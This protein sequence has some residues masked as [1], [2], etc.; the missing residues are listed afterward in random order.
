MVCL[1]LWEESAP[2]LIQVVS[3]ILLMDLRLRSHLLL[4]FTESTFTSKSLTLDLHMDP[5]FQSQ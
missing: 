2:K 4:T 5:L 3:K 1:S